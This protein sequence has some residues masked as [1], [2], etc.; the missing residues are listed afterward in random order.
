MNKTL[1]EKVENW[2][3]LYELLQ[4][5]LSTSHYTKAV[6]EINKMKKALLDTHN[7]QL[8]QSLEEMKDYKNGIPEPSK[9]YECDCGYGF[10]NCMCTHNN[11]LSK[12]QQLLGGRDET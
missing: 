5:N 6:S 1:S 9:E 4:S 12:A 2:K 11:A 3:E 8:Y 7:K 10:D